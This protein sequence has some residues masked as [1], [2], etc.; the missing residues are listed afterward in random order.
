ML[1]ERRQA[2]TYLFNYYLSN[3]AGSFFAWKRT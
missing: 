3:E 1:E 2:S